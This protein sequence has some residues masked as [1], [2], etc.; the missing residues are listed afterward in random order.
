[1]IRYIYEFK[2][3]VQGSEETKKKTLSTYVS[4][5]CNDS[6]I[7]ILLDILSRKIFVLTSITSLNPI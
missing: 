6:T 1:M 2:N 5:L 7:H 3:S 4:I